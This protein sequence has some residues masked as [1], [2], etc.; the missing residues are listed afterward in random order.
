MQSDGDVVL[1]SFNKASRDE[2]NN[3]DQINK[4]KYDNFYG[5]FNFITLHENV[6][7]YNSSAKTQFNEFL[8]VMCSIF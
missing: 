1:E 8:A 4:S 2:D 6:Y 3:S 7:Y 5:D